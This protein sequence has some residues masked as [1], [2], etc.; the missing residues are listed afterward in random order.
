[1]TLPPAPDDRQTV[2]ERARLER[3]AASR[4]PSFRRLAVN[5]LTIGVVAAALSFFAAPLVAFYGI[6]AA[7]GAGD[8]QGLM[9]LI[10][11]DAVRASLRPQLAGRALPRTPPPSMLED[12][13]GAVRRQFEQALP[14]P[15]TAG[16]DAEAYLA[17]GAL[18]GLTLGYGR[19]SPEISLRAQTRHAWPRPAY[20]SINRTRL[21]VGDTRIGSHTLFTFERMGPY[22][23]KLV[24]IGLPEPSSPV[25]LE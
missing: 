22:E 15:V 14:Q 4:R 3:E 16:P 25:A 7:A 11:Y 24:H 21:A 2:W 18:S 1:M 13:V 10:D 6:R 20:W 8:V 12:P 9:L 19:A 17:P 23:W 5:L